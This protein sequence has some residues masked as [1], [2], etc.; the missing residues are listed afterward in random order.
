MISA[1]LQ[2]LCEVMA[3]KRQR[4][5]AMAM[6]DEY[7]LWDAAT[8][9]STATA[10]ADPDC[11]DC[12]SVKTVTAVSTTQLAASA[13]PPHL[14]LQQQQR[15][16]D[17]LAIAVVP[18]SQKHL[19]AH[20]AVAKEDLKGAVPLDAAIDGNAAGVNQ[21]LARLLLHPEALGHEAVEPHGW[22]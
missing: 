3:V 16:T 6:R 22:Q 5:W 14:R 8:E 12:L 17:S 2:T 15:R 10:L 13:T 11:L 19:V 4:F 1:R 20:N 7:P 21:G 18:S 9:R